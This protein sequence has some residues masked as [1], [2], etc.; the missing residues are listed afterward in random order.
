MGYS[1]TDSCESVGISRSHYYE[2]ING[3][4]PRKKRTRD[5]S[6]LIDKVKE[7]KTAHPFWG[8][9]RIRAWLVHREGIL[10]NEKKVRRLMKENGLVAISHKYR[11]RRAAATQKAR[12]SR[13]HQVW[14]IDMTKFWIDSFGWAYLVIILDWYTKKTVGWDL[15]ARS[16]SEDWLKALDSA[17]L[18]EFPNG[19]RGHGLKLV[20]DNGCQPTSTA[21][22][23]A[24]ATLEI[25]QIYTSFNNPKGN[26]DTERMMRTIKEELIW[27]ND[28]ASFE[29]AKD[30][31][32]HW[33][34][35]DYNKLYV[36]SALGYR[37]PEEFA[38]QFDEIITTKAA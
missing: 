30:A 5:D 12:A 35:N 34:D 9:R 36:H 1:V 8:Y 17:V 11:I 22:M 33:T 4:T 18:N 38:K 25:E 26:A 20:S 10:I 28:F 23:K 21:F 37:S 15:S 7:L 3:T 13:P 19:T 27:L 2:R 32:A 14:G 29:Q 16:K 24:T 6:A 31:L